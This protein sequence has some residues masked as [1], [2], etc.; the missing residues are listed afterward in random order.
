MS[1]SGINLS[2][3]SNQYM[4]PSVTEL[5]ANAAT[6]NIQD[7]L[8]IM[9][10]PLAVPFSEINKQDIWKYNSN[11]SRPSLPPAHTIRMSGPERQTEESQSWVARREQLV[12]DLPEDI[13]EALI[14]NKGLSREQQFADFIALDEALTML[15]KALVIIES[16]GEPLLRETRAE[17]NQKLYQQIPTYAQEN[18]SHT[19]YEILNGIRDKMADMGRNNPSYDDIS[20]YT[21]LTQEGLETFNPKGTQS[22]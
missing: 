9:K 4:P 8:G 14:T 19:A 21:S 3:S 15:A 11:S 16:G 18:Y 20:Y 7:T 6:R 5:Q 12:K 13:Q 10:D 22:A 1:Y 2:S 17:Q